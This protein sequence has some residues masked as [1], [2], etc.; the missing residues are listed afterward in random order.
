MGQKTHGHEDPNC[1]GEIFESYSSLQVSL[2]NSRAPR[3]VALQET[4]VPSPSHHQG[5]QTT[6]RRVVLL[7]LLEGSFHISLTGTGCHYLEVK[8]GGWELVH[9]VKCFLCTA[10]AGVTKTRPSG[11]H[12]QPQLEEAEAGRSQELAGQPTYPTLLHTRVLGLMKLAL[13]ESSSEK[14]NQICLKS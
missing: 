12:M 10:T 13:P 6:Q 3:W 4:E 9:S 7:K 5:Q 1:L 2:L 11:E 8:R 14:V